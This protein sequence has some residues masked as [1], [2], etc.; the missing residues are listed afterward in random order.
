MAVNIE[1]SYAKKLGLPEFSSHQFSVS[2]TAEVARLEDVPGEVE[3]VYQ[4]LQ[5]SVDGQIVNAGFVPGKEPETPAH[6]SGNGDS[7]PWKCSDKQRAL[8]VKIVDE[9]KLDRS[10]VEQLAVTRFGHGV[11]QLN[12]LQASGLIDELLGKTGSTSAKKSGSFRPFE[13]RRAA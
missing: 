13:H 10:E 4:I 8:I 12:K 6:N 11:T 3:R 7:I 1:M 2:L 5:A 9:N